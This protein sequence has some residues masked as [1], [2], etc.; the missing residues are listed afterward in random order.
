MTERLNNNNQL[1]GRE[2][3]QTLGDSGG[4]RNLACCSLWGP[5]E[6]GVTEQILFRN[7]AAM[8]VNEIFLTLSILVTFWYQG[9]IEESLFF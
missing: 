8:F 3:E 1:S 2:F 4:Q 5:K 9:E 7:C 6:S